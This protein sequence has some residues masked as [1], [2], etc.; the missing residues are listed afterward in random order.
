MTGRCNTAWPPHWPAPPRPGPGAATAAE[1]AHGLR[2]HRCGC[3]RPMPKLTQLIATRA[4]VATLTTATARRFAP[5]LAA[6]RR[7]PRPGP[8]RGRPERAGERPLRRRDHRRRGR[9]RQPR[10]MLRSGRQRQA[11]AATTARHS[12]PPPTWATAWCAQ[13]PIAARAPLD[14]VNSTWTALIESIVLATAA[15]TTTRPRCRHTPRPAFMNPDRPPRNHAP[16][17]GAP[18]GL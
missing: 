8:G 17:G 12:S 2:G 7:D 11:I 6:G 10:C 9:R 18:A 16:A 14:H 15:A 13:V 4:D 1:T 5:S 3:S